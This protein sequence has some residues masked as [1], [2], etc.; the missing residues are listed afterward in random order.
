VTAGHVKRT[1][2]A[3]FHWVP[4]EWLPWPEALAHITESVG[5]PKLAHHELKARLCAKEIKAIDRCIGMD[6]QLTCTEL[7][8]DFLQKAAGAWSSAWKARE[9]LA[10]GRKRRAEP[11]PVDGDA[12]P[13]VNGFGAAVFERPGDH[14]IYLRRADV[15]KYWPD[16]SQLVNPP[17]ETAPRKTARGAKPE[18]DWEKIIIR[19]ACILLCEGIPESANRLMAQ[20]IEHY[21][22]EGG[23][24]ADSVMH[25]HLDPLYSAAKKAL[26]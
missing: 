10:A 3:P 22:W 12:D 1:L 18:Y 5:A 9:I 24:P 16:A 25:F 14:Y 19:G 7:E 26:E 6:G 21:D 20:V 15:L 8:V 2:L 17:R 4:A 23:R 13:W 11:E